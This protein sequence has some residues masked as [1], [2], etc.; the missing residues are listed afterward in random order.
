MLQFFDDL[1]SDRWAA[2]LHVDQH[3]RTRDLVEPA[4]PEKQRR[5]IQW[6]L[7]AAYELHL[8]ILPAW[9][10]EPGLLYRVAGEM[11]DELFASFERDLAGVMPK[12]ASL[13]GRSEARRISNAPMLDLAKAT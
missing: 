7:V 2:L 9:Q 1:P 12:I 5:Y 13:A 8:L 4:S 11:S 10:S 6:V 3:A